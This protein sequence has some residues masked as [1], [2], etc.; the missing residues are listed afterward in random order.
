MI[1]AV[2]LALI[3]SVTAPVIE[4]YQKELLLNALSAV[5]GSFAVSEESESA[6]DESGTV[7]NYYE[8]FQGDT[9]SGY[10]LS[11]Q[12]KGYGGSMELI[13]GFNLDGSLIHARLL[14][15]AETPG[16]GKEAEKDSYMEKFRG[17]GSDSPIPV[18][19]N[20]LIPAEADAISG[21]TITFS[22]IAKALTTGSQFVKT[23]SGN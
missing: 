8:L 1:A 13:A 22:A 17:T 6:D 9:V 2:A 23:M 4:E 19:K 3:N 15:N 14:G 5:S 21:A 12:A 18:R 11:L 16:L 10:V 7:I 20:Q